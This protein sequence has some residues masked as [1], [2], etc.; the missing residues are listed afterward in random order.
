MQ[1]K[2]SWFG[3]A[4]LAALA[5]LALTGRPAFGELF[6]RGT[7]TEGYHLIYDDSLDVTW[8]DYTFGCTGFGNTGYTRSY[9]FYCKDWADT[10]NI[11][12]NGQTFDDWRLPTV[13]PV[14]NYN[15]SFDGSTDFSYNILRTGSELAH[16]YHVTLGN[17]SQYDTAGNMRSAGTY[18]LLNTGLFNNL[19]GTPG[20]AIYWTQTGW[21]PNSGNQ[22]F[23]T[24]FSTGVQC[25]TSTQSGNQAWALALRDGDVVPEP[26]TLSLS[27]LALAGLTFAAVVRRR[28][29]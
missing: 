2:T 18:G 28:R 13:A 3:H 24:Q 16:L 12:I 29:K 7:S 6:N 26:A 19:D 14:W 8:V 27:L 1:W 4:L 15:Y 10:L 20:G 23:G 22:M 9:Y 11:T 25:P 17:L 5:C 21:P